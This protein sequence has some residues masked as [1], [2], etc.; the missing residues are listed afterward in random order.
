LTVIV[1]FVGAGCAVMA[2]DSEGTESDHTRFDVEKIWTTGDCLLLGYSGNTAVRDALALSIEAAIKTNFGLDAKEIPRQEARTAL[3]AASQ[4]VLRQYYSEYVPTTQNV[5]AIGGTLLV[6]G[7]DGEGLWLLEIDMNN[8][9]TFYESRGYQAIGSGGPAAFTAQGLLGHYEPA[10]QTIEE[11][12]LIAYRTVKTCIDG[13][14]GPMGVGGDVHIWSCKAGD[15]YA[16]A[17][18]EI[19]ESLDEGLTKW[20][21]IERESLA[22]VFGTAPAE[23]ADAEEGVPDAIVE[24]PEAGAEE[25]SEE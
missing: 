8:T 3:A 12:R 15:G 1:G 13:L 24:E 7:R 11:L 2:S 9:T 22:E 14:G 6:I 17:A 18:P 10:D 25:P 23:V 20:K 19:V 4:P 5:N 21:T 16:K